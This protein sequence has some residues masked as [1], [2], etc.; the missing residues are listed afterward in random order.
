MGNPEKG[1]CGLYD[2]ATHGGHRSLRR[3]LW[4]NEG[5]ANKHE[6]RVEDEELGWRRRQNRGKEGG[7]A[8]NCCATKI[9]GIKTRANKR[10]IRWKEMA[11]VRGKVALGLD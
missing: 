2:D 11:G 7:G 3:G 6:R 5:E 9:I 4:A 8:A 10:G 1:E